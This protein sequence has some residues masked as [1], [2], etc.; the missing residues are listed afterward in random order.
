MLDCHG[1][2]EIFLTE[3]FS[4]LKERKV[5]MRVSFDPICPERVDGIFLEEERKTFV[6]G[7]GLENKYEQIK[8]GKTGKS[9]ND[10]ED[11]KVMFI[12][13]KRFLDAE[14][15][16]DIRSEL[17]Y[18]ERLSESSLD[19]ALHALS[20][21]KVYHFLLEDI[22]GKTMDWSKFESISVKNE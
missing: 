17:R 11:K 20:K 13:T 19:G 9:E 2:G 6:T 4:R 22:Y 7:R 12:N 21:A 5:S 8:R 3:L 15:L 1:A 14:K 18:V 10:D 16:R